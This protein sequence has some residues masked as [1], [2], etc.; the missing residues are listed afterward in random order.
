MAE[1][2]TGDA[3]IIASVVDQAKALLAEQAADAEQL[4]LLEPVTPED[5]VEARAALGPN[6]GQLAVVLAARERKRG[7]PPGARNKRTDDFARYLLQFGTHPAITMMQIQA[8]E[9]EMLIEASRTEVRTGL[10]RDGKPETV[11]REM[12]YEAAQALRV[13]CAEGLLPYLESKKPVAIDATIRGV[14]IHET[15]GGHEAAT[16]DGG[17]IV[18]VAAPG[19]DFGGFGGVAA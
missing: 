16:V 9:P 18:G 14:H 1:A 3:A 17:E 19:D 13:R 4:D 10:I 8:T 7:R 2:A 5:M 11:F 12:T 15:I 6:A